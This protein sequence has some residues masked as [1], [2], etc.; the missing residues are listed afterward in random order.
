MQESNVNSLTTGSN[1]LDV[2]GISA[3]E[4]VISNLLVHCYNKSAEFRESFL[5]AIGLSEKDSAVRGQA[6]LRVWTRFGVPDIVILNRDDCRLLIIENKLGADEGKEQ[7]IRYASENCLQAIEQSLNFSACRDKTHYV[8]LTLFPDQPC[9][10]P[11][12]VRIQYENFLPQDWSL[13][14][15]D[16][17]LVKL[18]AK[19]WADLLI[20]FYNAANVNPTDIL[21]ERMQ[22]PG[23][24][25]EAFLV[26][27][28]FMRSV[29]LP[30]GISVRSL[31]YSAQG[32]KNYKAQFGKASWSPSEIA[33]RGE[34]W[35]LDPET[36]FNIHIEPTLNVLDGNFSVS[37]HYETNPYLK[38][39]DAART[40]NADDLEG[41]RR[42]RSEFVW[43][44]REVRPIG[45]TP[46]QCD[47]WCQVGKSDFSINNLTVAESQESFSVLLADIVAAVDCALE[48]ISDGAG[49]A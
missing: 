48:R 43:A 7:T 38:E 4:D 35:R 41:Y 14:L 20:G 30:T 27:R 16:D 3:R 33:K 49:P 13:S 8:F 2:L 36:C 26:F 19:S 15:C 37:L 40:L 9:A 25:D 28:N 47:L 5:R 44:F 39:T 17:P 24:L 12:F 46:A 23:P 42:K 10:A 31:R 11:E 22:H 1:V 21:V 29:T 34:Q 32:R 18:L 6:H 45:L